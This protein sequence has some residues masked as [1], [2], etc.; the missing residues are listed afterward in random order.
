MVL[1]KPDLNKPAFIAL[2]DAKEAVIKDVCPTCGAPIREE[3]FR[4]GLSRREYGIY[5]MCQKCQDSV[6]GGGDGALRMRRR[7]RR[8]EG[9]HTR[10]VLLPEDLHQEAGGRGQEK[11]RRLI[12]YDH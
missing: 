9:A 3:D 1:Q 12:T 2:P 10:P 6:F 8:G 5:G 4:D 11:S 7:Y